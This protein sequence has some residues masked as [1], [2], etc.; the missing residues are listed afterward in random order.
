MHKLSIPVMFT[1]MTDETRPKYAEIFKTSSVD[2]VFL[3][4]NDPIF[5][6]KYISENEEKVKKDIA[7]FK[8]QGFEVG[9]WMNAFGHGGPLSHDVDGLAVSDNFTKLE[10]IG[11]KN[12][13]SYCPLDENFADLYAKVIQ[14][15]ANAGPAIIMLDDDYRLNYRNYRMGCTCPLHLNAYYERIGEVIPKEQLEQK[16]FSGGENFYRTEWLKLMGETL[17]D[18]AKKMRSALNEVDSTI[19]LG[20]CQC[21]DTWDFEG[22]DGIEL[23]KAFAGDTK[24]FL[25]TIGAAYHNV[26]VPLTI[27]TNRVQAHWCRDT[28][29]EVFC[30]GDVYPRPRYN[31]PSRYLELF[32]LGLLASG[33]TDGILKYMFDYNR[34]AEYE[35]GYFKR[36][37]KNEALRNQVKEIFDGKKATGVY[38]VDEMRKTKQWHLPVETPE[39]VSDYICAALENARQAKAILVSNAIP[40]TYEKAG[41]PLCIMG[42]NAWYAEKEDLQNGSIIDISAAKI[43]TERGIDVGLGSAKAASV[44]G[45]TYLTEND[46]ITGFEG[47]ELYEITCSSEAKIETV[48][49][50]QNTPGSYRYEN[51]E[52][53][54]FFVLACSLL[55]EDFGMVKDNANYTANYYRKKQLVSA[56]EWVSGKKMAAQTTAKCPNL[57]TIVSEQEDYSRLS[58][59]VINA[60]TDDAFDIEFELGKTYESI[61]FINCEGSFDG[62]KVTVD[63]M[64]PYGFAAFEVR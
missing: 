43:L 21:W 11:G 50:P 22:T 52:G 56:I 51:A 64:E 54:R 34:P 4:I 26:S 14:M 48:F 24:P 35:C 41:H 2:R 61:R 18:F 16:V 28:G 9:V 27:E 36:H 17:V 38:I 58:T 31:V 7:Y 53:Q 30:E 62:S 15:I 13:Y 60:F 6:E 8:S 20:I 12:E 5:A 3:C 49:V 39:G 10:G 1:S 46:T 19:R 59:A 42:E 40:V 47:M 33:E 25:R 23:A 63:Y 57:Y 32:D 45:E 37:Q 29:V 55:R 44:A